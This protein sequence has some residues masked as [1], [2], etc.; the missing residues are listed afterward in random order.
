M[1]K[2]RTIMVIFIALHS[3]LYGGTKIRGVAIFNPGNRPEVVDL[4]PNIYGAEQAVRVAGLPYIITKKMEQAS[5]YSMMLIC[6][7]VNQ[8]TLSSKEKNTLIEYVRNGGILLSP[9][10]TDETLFFIAGISGTLAKNTR[11]RISWNMQSKDPSLKWFDDPMEKT[12]SIGNKKY[13]YSFETFSFYLNGA[14]PLAFFDDKTVA[15]TGYEYGK[16]YTY[17]LGFQFKDF[18]TRG[19]LGKSDASRTYS[20][21]FE[22]S[23]D[24]I[25]LFIRALFGKHIKYSSWK[26]TSPFLSKATFIMTHDLCAKSCVEKMEDFA[27]MEYEY[28]IT[29]D[30][31]VTTAYRRYD[32]RDFGGFY[33][34]EEISTLKRILN[35]NHRMT[36]HSVNHFPDFDTFPEGKPGNTKENYKPTYDGKRTHGGTVFG[37][38]E[39]SKKLIDHDVGVN[40]RT[41][42]SGYL[43][44]NDKLYNVLE[45]A[46]Y[47]YD[48]TRSANEMLTNFPFP[49]IKD[50]IYDGEISTIYEIPMTI[51][52]VIEGF[53]SANYK[54]IADLWL[55]ITLRNA[56]NYAPTI[57]LIHPNRDFKKMAEER[58][59]KNLPS[60]INITN[61]D[62]FGDF[63]RKRDVFSFSTELTENSLKIIIHDKSFPIDA[64]QSII[65]ENGKNLSSI[66][67]VRSSGEPVPFIK[68][69]WGENDILIHW[70]LRLKTE[71]NEEHAWSISKLV[72]RLVIFLTGTPE[73]T[74]SKFIVYRKINNEEYKPIHYFYPQNFSNGKYLFYDEEIEDGRVHTYKIGI[75]D[76]KGRVFAF[77]NERTI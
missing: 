41:F 63:W 14:F 6:V 58:L 50:R 43:I 77:S 49:G 29:A 34:E 2:M 13:S 53:S 4:K 12:I 45:A 7:P 33:D 64:S 26:K 20:N 74:Y 10:I 70:G 25:M 5:S 54:E 51:S 44:F 67:V 39:L 59:L 16:G 11:M 31:D 30:Y 1:L 46:G 18:I 52:D 27:D 37:E 71:R 24:T 69:S 8:G 36:S 40:V 23:A 32:N 19:F 56:K 68:T 73:G 75:V 62:Y 47:S 76:S 57:L 15:V 48:S 38:V 61:I 42:R 3:F 72:G 21:G 17:L 60:F 9:Y 22:P 35:K 55:D 66:K 28:G 65:V